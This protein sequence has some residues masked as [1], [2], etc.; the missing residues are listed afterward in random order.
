MTKGSIST[1]PDQGNL[2]Q[3][4]PNQGHLSHHWKTYI[5]NHLL[6]NK[7]RSRKSWS[8]IFEPHLYVES[9]NCTISQTNPYRG[10]P[11][12]GHL[13]HHWKTYIKNHLLL[14]KFRSRKSWSRI[15]EPHLYVESK[16]CTISQT[17]PYR[18]N[19]DQGHLSHHRMTIRKKKPPI[20]KSWSR[21]SQT[22]RNEPPSSP[23]TNQPSLENTIHVQT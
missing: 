21:K 23:Q 1:D 19:P 14:N 4:N 2:W 20:N 8:R 15:F 17:N 6:L 9:K 3:R 10:N 5:K 7:F 12:Q 13:S 16:N 11:N 22:R 18:G